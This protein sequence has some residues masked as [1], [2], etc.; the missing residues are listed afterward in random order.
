MAINMIDEYFS[1]VNLASRSQT[2]Y[3][4]VLLA[5]FKALGEEPITRQAITTYLNQEKAHIGLR[6]YN[7]RLI[8]IKNYCKY[9]Y[10]EDKLEEKE[11]KKI[12]GLKRMKDNNSTDERRALT[13]QEQE[14]ALQLPDPLHRMLCW[15]GLNYGL[16]LSEYQ[17]L[18][19]SDVDLT[20]RILTIRQSKGDKT[21]KIK[22]LREHV[23]TWQTWIKYRQT[24]PN[25]NTHN[26]VFCSPKGKFHKR[27]LERTFQVI[28]QKILLSQHEGDSLSSHSFRYTFAVSKWKKGMDILILSK[29]LGHASIQTTQ[30]YL[31][32]TEEE[33]LSKYELQA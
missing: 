29:I 15:T 24:Y 5:F 9:L 4:Y 6:T 11:Y 14:K 23:A 19:L 22:I 8:V 13:P 17:K 25:T 20:N 28:C 30:I 3:N 32:V 12:M 1:T 26:F 27:A 33:I 21:R 16:R 31:K 18:E 7:L 2:E 10:Q